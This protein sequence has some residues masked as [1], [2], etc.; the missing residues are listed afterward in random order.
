MP[1][2]IWSYVVFVVAVAR[3]GQQMVARVAAVA[4]KEGLTST[5]PER[6]AAH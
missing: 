3:P 4:A 2:E 1:V 5:L 6:T